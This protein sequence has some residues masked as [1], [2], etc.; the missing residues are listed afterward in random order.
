M[1]RNVNEG[2]CLSPVFTPHRVAAIAS[3]ADTPYAGITSSQGMDTKGYDDLAIQIAITGTG[4]LT[5]SVLVW[6]DRLSAFI[7][8]SPAATFTLTASAQ[9]KFASLG[10]RI[11][12]RLSSPDFGTTLTQVDVDVAAGTLRN[13]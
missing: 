2:I 6:S 1:S 10:Q 7:P 9:I 3:D 4:S 8:A 11:F 13:I 12:V 5:A